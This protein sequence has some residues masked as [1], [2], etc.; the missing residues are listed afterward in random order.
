MRKG[1]SIRVRFSPA[2][3]LDRIDVGGID[4]QWKSDMEARVRT[5]DGKWLR[6]LSQAWQIDPPVD[7]RRAAAQVLKRQG[8]H[9]VVIGR[10]GWR[11]DL[12]M[13]DPAAWGLHEVIGTPNATLYEID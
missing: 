2:Q 7:R 9:Y 12:F 8:I 1:M 6:P 11:T 5:E 10:L 3:W 4:G 13:K